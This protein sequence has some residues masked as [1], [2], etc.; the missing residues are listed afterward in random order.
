LKRL[1][2]SFN[3]EASKIIEDIEQGRE[4]QLDLANLALFSAS[5]SEL[6]PTSFNDAWNHADPKN[7]ELWR[8]A[9]NKE[10]G[11]MENKQGREIIDKEDV[12]EGRRTVKR[13]WISKLKETAYFKLD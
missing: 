2:S 11:E 5:A 4:I 8:I 13:K 1:E 7:R 3:L 10:L 6:E 9:I 12:P